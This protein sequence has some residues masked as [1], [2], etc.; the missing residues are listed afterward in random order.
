MKDPIPPAGRSAENTQVILTVNHKRHEFEIDRDIRTSDSLATVLREKLGLTGLKIAC[1]DGGC[2]ACTVLMDGRAV[3]SC[4][5]L[6]VDAQHADILTIEGLPEDDPVI[7]AVAEQSEPGYG[8][9]LQCGYC[10][11]G[12]VLSIKGLLN[13]NPDPSIDQVREGLSGNL[14]RCGCYSAIGR[15]ALH[16]AGKMGKGKGTSK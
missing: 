12:V 13:E 8:T 6:A 11:P 1:N 9:A 2:G 15:A 5:I 10:T 16:A 3:L 14:C 4:M 7:E